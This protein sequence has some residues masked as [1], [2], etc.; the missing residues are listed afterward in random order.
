MTL[1]V[2]ACTAGCVWICTAAVPAQG[3]PPGPLALAVA[4][5]AHRIASSTE[6]PRV[7]APMGTPRTADS[8]PVELRWN[9]LAPMIQG[10]RVTVTLAGGQT[11][12][13]TAVTVRDDALVMDVKESS[14]RRTYPN[15]S[16]TFPRATISRIT[17]QRTRGSSGRTLGTVIG[18]LTGV[19]VG[20][21]VAETTTDSAGT[22]IPLF[23]GL[24]SG[25][26]I[27]GYYVGR[28]LDRE[29]T[30]IRVVP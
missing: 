18:V 20:G 28:E 23:L 6:D 19:V 9:E 29:V 3:A 15:G 24:A 25:T 16:G 11:V 4:R 27:A 10:Q 13:G 1:R 5:E 8:R 21:Y 12:A 7:V 26:T 22:G 2:A 14:D 30:E 17:L